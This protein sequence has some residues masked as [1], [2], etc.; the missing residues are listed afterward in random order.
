MVMKGNKP[1]AQ[2]R[3]LFLYLSCGVGESSLG[4][5]FLKKKDGVAL[6]NSGRK[7]VS[8]KNEE[9]ELKKCLVIHVITNSVQ[10][11]LRLG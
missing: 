10:Y 5:C 1:I 9:A 11:Y 7:H 6:E 4:L 2:C 8:W 3:S